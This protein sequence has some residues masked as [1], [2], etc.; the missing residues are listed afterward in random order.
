MVRKLPNMNALRAF[1]CAARLESFSR[2]A[3]ELCV[4][5]GAISWHI[6]RLEA[7]LGVP[8]FKRQTRAVE[9]TDYGREYLP[10]TR[11]AFDQIEQATVRMERLSH[12]RA[13]VADVLPTF[14]MR[15]LV[16]RLAT[17]NDEN[18]DIEI[19][20][21]TSIKPVDFQRDDVD[22]AIRV[23]T[24]PGTTVRRGPRIN[25][26]MAT[27]WS[28]IHSEKLMPDVLVPVCSPVLFTTVDAP[29][30]LPDLQRFPLLHNATRP[31]A[32][33]DWFHAV[34]GVESASK[35]KGPSFGHFF[36]TIQAAI[37]GRGIALVPKALVENDLEENRLIVVLDIPVP[38]TGDYYFLC[39]KSQVDLP[40]I[41]RFRD[42]LFKQCR[43]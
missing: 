39:R 37:E 12:S 21:L 4:T 16:P 34:T 22:V 3:D 13:L 7:Y 42:W 32:W 38:S 19:H 5:Q 1:E 25:L 20:L 36:M 41:Q 30:S 8:L 17:F 29:A 11:E 23:G 14:A 6:K 2:A 26:E 15:W 9:L 43:T 40:A 10:A 24:P 35:L 18:P 31:D 27:D 28:G 33:P